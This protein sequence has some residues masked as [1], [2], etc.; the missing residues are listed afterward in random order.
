[1]IGRARWR[2]GAAWR[3]STGNLQGLP[4]E[5]WND[6]PCRGG[7]ASDGGCDPLAGDPLILVG[8]EPVVPGIDFELGPTIFADGF[9]SGDVSAWSNAVP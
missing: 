9:E 8:A 4:D 6:I 1:M 2:P 5:L 7:A 3:F